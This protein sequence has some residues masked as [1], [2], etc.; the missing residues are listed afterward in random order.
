MRAT[1]KKL[2]EQPFA[3][4]LQN[5]CS[6]K[7]YQK[8]TTTQVFFSEISKTIEN[9]FFFFLQN[10]PV[11]TSEIKHILQLLIYYILEQK[12][13]IGMREPFEKN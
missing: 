10:T 5:R 12:I 2:Q 4:I 8:E 11:T 13:S 6:K 9:I 7:P 1:R 3:Y